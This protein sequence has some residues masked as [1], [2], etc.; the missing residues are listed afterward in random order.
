MR[1]SH[2]YS[3]YTYDPNH[4]SLFLFFNSWSSLYIFSF[5]VSV[6]LS[7][8]I[9]SSK[10]LTWL[11][12]W[13]YVFHAHIVY[14]SLASFSS[15]AYTFLHSTWNSNQFSCSH[16]ER[17]YFLCFIWCPSV[18]FS[19]GCIDLGSSLNFEMLGV[20]FECWDW[21]CVER[22]D[23]WN[24]RKGVILLAKRLKLGKFVDFEQWKNWKKCEIKNTNKSIWSG[25]HCTVCEL[26][27][28]M[29]TIFLV[30]MKWK[31]I[32]KHATWPLTNRKN[33]FRKIIP[34]FAVPFWNIDSKILY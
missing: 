13:F 7:S 33:L 4:S 19:I 30:G 12:R 11:Q 28:T 14:F 8:K 2:R 6:I 27:I 1:V 22:W 16:E 23:N 31:Y 34:K 18:H 9:S 32:F 17:N 21:C 24:T 29:C 26:A 20:G 10:H 25:Q 3:L 15:N 5:I